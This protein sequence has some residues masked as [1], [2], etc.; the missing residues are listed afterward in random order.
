VQ[1]VAPG[2]REILTQYDVNLVIISSNTSLDYAL[3]HDTTWHVGYR[4]DTAVVYQKN[5]CLL[6]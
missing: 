3:A 6:A 4:D 1:N 2:W 5:L